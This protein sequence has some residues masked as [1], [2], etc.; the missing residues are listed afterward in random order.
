MSFGSGSGESPAGAPADTAFFSACGIHYLFPSAT[1]SIR[2]VAEKNGGKLRCFSHSCCGLIPQ[3]AGDPQTARELAQKNIRDF[4]AL[5]SGTLLVSDDSCAGFMKS[6]PALLPDDAKAGDFASKVKNLSEFLA[7]RGYKG[8]ES[9][10]LPRRPV[11]VATVPGLKVTYHDPCQTGNGQKSFA[12]PRAILK[13]IPGIEVVELDEAEWCC[14]GAGTYSLKHPDLAD[15]VLERKMA[16][17]K[18]SGAA[19]VVT[20]AA[21]C[22]LH[23]GLGLRR[24]GWEGNIRVVHL[25]DFLEEISPGGRIRPERP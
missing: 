16:N 15:D 4:S 3:S 18:K 7:E 11:A 19:V 5:G 21:S 22:L 23:V 24:K 9:A 10:G 6:Y 20:Q 12:T 1:K 13:S 2:S 25:A 8:P 17:I 14:G